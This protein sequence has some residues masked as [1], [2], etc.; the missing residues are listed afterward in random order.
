[1]SQR[2]AFLVWSAGV[3]EPVITVI[4]GILA[5]VGRQTTQHDEDIVQ[6]LEPGQLEY[7]H[8]LSKPASSALLFEGL[9]PAGA[10]VTSTKTVGGRIIAVTLGVASNPAAGAGVWL[11]GKLSY[12]ATADAYR[13]TQAVNAKHVHFLVSARQGA[14]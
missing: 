5:A 12:R 1:V 6:F 7:T 9:H 10:A 3:T 13:V 2:P 4:G 14:A 8:T 11:V